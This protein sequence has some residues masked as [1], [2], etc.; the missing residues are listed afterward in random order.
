MR[1]WVPILLSHLAWL[2][3]GAA[4]GAS[5]LF[6]DDTVLEL[7]LRGPLSATLGDTGERAERPFVLTVEGVDLDI[8]ARVRGKSR[9][10]TCSF[11]PLRLD[12]SNPADTVF[13]GQGSLKLVTHCNRASSYEINVLEEYAAYRLVSLLVPTALG[14]RLVRMR[15]VDTEKPGKEPLERF[16]AKSISPNLTSIAGAVQQYLDKR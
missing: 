7:E 11:P 1:R 2:L 13:A 4:A 14:A 6:E 16:I 3:C 9:A 12:F 8:M 5:P 15:Y 10:E